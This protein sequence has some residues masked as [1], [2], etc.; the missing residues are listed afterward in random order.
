METVTSPHGDSDI[1]LAVGGACGE[2]AF[3]VDSAHGGIG[4][5]GNI[6]RVHGHRQVIP[7]AG[8]GEL[9]LLSRLQVQG[10]HLG[11]GVLPGDVE[12]GQLI[13]YLYG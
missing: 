1:S 9:H 7:D 4:C 3:G 12:G 2:A 8:C 11:G 10:V 6:V 13:H 5:P